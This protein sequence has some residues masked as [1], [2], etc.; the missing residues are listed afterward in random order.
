MVRVGLKNG[1]LN[2][3]FLQKYPLVKA[4][5]IDRNLKKDISLYFMFICVSCRIMMLNTL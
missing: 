5:S 2:L 3:F 4:L 1:F